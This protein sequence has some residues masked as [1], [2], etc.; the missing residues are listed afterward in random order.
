MAVIDKEYDT[1]MLK[2]RLQERYGT[3][4]CLRCSP[5]GGCC[6]QHKSRVPRCD[7]GKNKRRK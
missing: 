7:R 2:R 4:V 1:K 6:N 3:F 5:H